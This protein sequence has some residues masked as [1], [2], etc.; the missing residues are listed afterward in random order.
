MPKCVIIF[1][2]QNIKNIFIDEKMMK[3][4]KVF[5]TKDYLT[6]TVTRS[7]DCISITRSREMPVYLV[8]Y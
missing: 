8:R 4:L 7:A 1:T 6:E 2:K 5:T 3:Y